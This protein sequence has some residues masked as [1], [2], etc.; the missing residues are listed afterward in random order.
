VAAGNNVTMTHEAEFGPAMAVLTEKQRAFVMAMINYPG[1]TQY[2]AAKRAGYT[3]NSEVGQRV[4]GH[5]AAHNPKVQ[6]AIREEA[7]KRLNSLSLRASNFLMEVLDDDAAPLKERTKAALAVLDR[8]GFAAAQ[9][10]NVNKTVTDQTGAAIM[11]RILALAEKHG[12]DP[13]RLLGRPV[14]QPAVD[15]EFSEVK[16]G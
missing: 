11:S 3:P 1:I 9:N 14:A 6:A 12:L 16:D 2:E 10:I 7:G 13:A 8:T 15:A 4:K 5:Y